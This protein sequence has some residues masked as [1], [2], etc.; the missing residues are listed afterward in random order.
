MTRLRA[1]L[2]DLAGDMPEP[3]F[4]DDLAGIALANHERKRRRITMATAFFATVATVGAITAG[5]TLTGARHADVDAATKALPELPAEPV[6]ALSYAYR[7]SCETEPEL[8]CSAVEWRVV[9]RAGKEYRVPQALGYTRQANSVPVAISRDGSKLAYYGKD[10]QAHVVHDVVT[11]EETVS[12]VKVAQ[13]RIG[14]GSMLVVSEDGR[15]LAFDPREGS[16]RPGLL[17]DLSS[18]KTRSLNAKYEPVSI[19]DGK[20]E[21][22]RY[23]RTD[24]WLMPV[25]GGGKPVNFPGPYIF[26]SEV[27]PDHRTVAALDFDDKNKVTLLDS[28]TGKRLRKVT[29]KNVPAKGTHVGTRI[30]ASPSEVVLDYEVRG[31]LRSYALNVKTGRL[32][33]LEDYS[34]AF[35]T[36]SVLPGGY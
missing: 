32:R 5:M 16:K 8:D 7:T 33:H 15:Y 29:V 12:P 21:L 30:W 2:R 11:G 26:F 34:D 25:T 35:F 13:D 23:R 10:E 31:S 24:L 9:T 27:A 22:V 19:K 20:V 17:I 14:V 1:A 36:S 28:T 18:G 4:T 6:G 3:A